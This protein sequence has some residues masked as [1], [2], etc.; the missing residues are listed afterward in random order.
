VASSSSIQ[1]LAM[2]IDYGESY[3]IMPRTIEI[4]E[5]E[6]IV[7]VE[8]LV[9]FVSLTHHGVTRRKTAFCDF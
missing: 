4:K 1:S 7:Q 2:Q 5:N 3:H 6:A 9:D 8:C